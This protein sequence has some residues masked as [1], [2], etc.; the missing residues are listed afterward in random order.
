MLTVSHQAQQ[1]CPLPYSPCAHLERDFEWKHQ[2]LLE[3]G[4]A[5][6]CGIFQKLLTALH[7]TPIGKPS[8]L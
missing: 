2:W 5:L 3:G 4:F 8:L 7:P 6:C 1:S